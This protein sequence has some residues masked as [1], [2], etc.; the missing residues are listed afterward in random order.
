MAEQEAGHQPLTRSTS[1][2]SSASTRSTFRAALI[3]RHVDPPTLSRIRHGA[4]CRLRARCG[5]GPPPRD[6]CDGGCRARTGWGGRFRFGARCGGGPS[7][8]FAAAAGLPSRSSRCA[9]RRASSSARPTTATPTQG[10]AGQ[11]RAR[12]HA[13]PLPTAARTIGTSG[14][15]APSSPSTTRPRRWAARRPRSSLV[16]VSIPL[17]LSL[18][19]LRATGEPSR[20]CRSAAL[21]RL[22]RG[23][24]ES[25]SRP[26]RMSRSGCVPVVS[27][28]LQ[29]AV[30]RRI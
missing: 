3:R 9:S 23:Y 11:R 14:C 19:D 29:P 18:P 7:F 24:R 1:S 8:E 30:A 6:C 4:R 12:C 17:P 13:A 16:E 2:T 10:R 5:G 20:S 25:L 27:G 28:Q 26:A 21:A 15:P 22:D